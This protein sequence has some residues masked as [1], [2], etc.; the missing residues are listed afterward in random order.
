MPSHYDRVNDL[1][2]VLG[3]TYVCMVFVL[4]QI[5]VCPMLC[6]CI[7][8]NIKSRKRPSV[9]PVSVDKNVT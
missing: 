6:I 7:G 8:Q 3:F 5:I 1:G 9:R 2:L 4:K